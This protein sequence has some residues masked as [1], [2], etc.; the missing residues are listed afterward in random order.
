MWHL[1]KLYAY[2]LTYLY[3]LRSDANVWQK[4]M[5]DD[6]IIYFSLKLKM[7]NG[8]KKKSLIFWYSKIWAP[9]D[10]R[11]VAGYAKKSCVSQVISLKIGTLCICLYVS[12]W[13]ALYSLCVS[14][15]MFILVNWVKHIP[16]N[17]QIHITI[18]INFML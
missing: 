9:R 1:S 14:T 15:T 13:C 16:I 11:Y 5:L 7:L 17:S 12:K 2:M 3:S 10:R 4:F 6:K 18:H 8:R